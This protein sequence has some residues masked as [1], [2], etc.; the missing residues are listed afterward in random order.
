MSTQEIERETEE[1][2]E[3]LAT[4][5]TPENQ[6]TEVQ[7]SEPETEPELEALEP[8]PKWDRRYKDAFTELGG[9]ENGR[10]YQQAMLDLYKEEQA[11]FT[12]T[13][14][15]RAEYER[16]LKNYRGVHEP[17]QEFLMKNGMTPHAAYRQGMG[18]LVSISQDPE[19]FVK[20]LAKRVGLQFADEEQAY[21]P[22][23]VQ[24]MQSELQQLKQ[25]LQSSQN[26]MQQQ[27]R[28]RV[29]QQI[30]SF[31]SEQ[32]ESGL[33]HPHFQEVQDH[34]GKLITAGLATSLQQAYDLAC[35]LSPD[36]STQETQKRSTDEAARKSADAKKA[37][38]A[39]R[40]APGKSV[41]KDNRE[42]S[43]EDAIRAALKEQAA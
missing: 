13:A 22:P 6:E 8:A 20:Q 27:E 15:E 38:D 21:V 41:G 5:E 3:A 9:I 7:E 12:K 25:Y 40:R 11:N 26:Q 16:E 34:M 33:T 1:I 10:T 2:A 23:E 42:L 29:T 31:A 32:D 18:L 35:K 17:Y 24:S 14:Q 19:S 43:D 4:S 28:A 37:K 30:Q 39:A 36:I